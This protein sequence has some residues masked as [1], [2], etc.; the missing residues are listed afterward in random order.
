MMD[1]KKIYNQIIENALVRQRNFPTTSTTTN[2]VV[3]YHSHHILPRSLGGSDSPDNL[4]KLTPKE[5]MTVH[6]LLAKFVDSNQWFAVELL[7]ALTPTKK[8]PKW[9]L[10]RIALQRAVLYREKINKNVTLRSLLNLRN[11]V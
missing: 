6:T 11:V 3:K 2:T 4:V 1:W 8:L 5:H 10:R 9:K 7:R